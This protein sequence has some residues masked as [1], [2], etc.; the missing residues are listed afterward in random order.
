MKSKS[1]NPIYTFAS[2]QSEIPCRKHLAGLVAVAF[3]YSSIITEKVSNKFGRINFLITLSLS[4]I[5]SLNNARNIQP[6]Y[7]GCKGSYFDLLQP[8][9][10]SIHPINF[11]VMDNVKDILIILCVVALVIYTIYFIFHLD[12][13]RRGLEDVENFR[14]CMEDPKYEEAFT[15]YHNKL[16]EEGKFPKRKIPKWKM[17]WMDFCMKLHHIYK[18]N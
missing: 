5:C 4:H 3:K 7:K 13:F 10:V 15:A 14:R 17:W 8:L 1:S 16:I 2:M 11:T 12:D 9:L 6:I 18:S